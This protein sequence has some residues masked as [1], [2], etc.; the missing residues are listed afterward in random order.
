MTP[1]LDSHERPVE[2]EPGFETVSLEPVGVEVRGLD[3]RRPISTAVWQRLREA[4]VREG[5]VLFR[6]Q[7]LTT[8][9]Q[10]ALGRRFGVLEN[11]SLDGGEIDESSFLL[12]NVGQDGALLPADAIE[13]KL[14]AINEGWHT[15]S[16]FREV[17]ASFSLFSGVVVP[18]VGGDTFFASLQ[19]GWDALSRDEQEELIGLVGHHNYDRAYQ[20][21]GVDMTEYF[22]GAAPSATHP[23]ARVHPESGRVGLF[24]SEHLYAIEGMEAADADERVRKLLAVCTAPEHVYRHRWAAGDLLIWDNRSMLHK[25]EGFDTEHPRVMRHVRIAGTEPGIA[26]TSV[27]GRTG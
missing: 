11:T 14:V 15:D 17:A 2:S 26:A 7:P 10:V 3:L 4:V 8:A 9:E 24:V 27:A 12:S 25:A 13:H 18:E 16:S 5:L 19:R 20:S 1:S 22:G 21:R 6:E 23:L